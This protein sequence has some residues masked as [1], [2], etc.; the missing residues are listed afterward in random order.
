MKGMKRD[1]DAISDLQREEQELFEKAESMADYKWM[2]YHMFRATE[3]AIRMLQRVQ[4]E[5]EDYFLDVL[6]DE[7]LGL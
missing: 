4:E 5:C 2:Y 6:P 7:D 3:R 1:R